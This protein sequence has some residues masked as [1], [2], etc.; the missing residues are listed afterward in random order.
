MILVAMDWRLCFTSAWSYLK[1]Y[2]AIDACSDD[3]LALA[4]Y[5]AEENL[6]NYKLCQY[7]QHVI[8]CS[9]LYLANRF[10]NKQVLWSK[11]VEQ[12][13]GLREKDLKACTKTMCFHLKKQKR[14]N[15]MT[16]VRRKFATE[17]FFCVSSLAEIRS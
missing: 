7:S 13:S 12:A 4:R 11:E 3:H 8:A 15:E 10:R 14:Q 16:A 2:A 1:R 9:A 17:E 5:F 6:L